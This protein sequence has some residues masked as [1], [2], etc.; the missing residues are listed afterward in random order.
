MQQFKVSFF[1][2]SKRNKEGK[3]LVQVRINL[4]GSRMFLCGTDI[5]LSASDWDS[6]LERVK[7]KTAEGRM[8][9]NRLESLES[10]V[11]HIFHKHEYDQNLSLDLI[12]SIYKG[13]V[14]T[15]NAKE[16]FMKFFERHV[17]DRKAE[18]GS[19]IS[20]SCYYKYSLTYR[21]F[22][23][24]L[25][26]EY[27]R[28]DISFCELDYTIITSFE[29]YMRK[30]LP[31]C[32]NNTL[33]RKMRVLKTIMIDARKH[34]MLNRDPFAGY[35]VHFTPTNRGFL[36]DEEVQRLIEKE[37][38]SKRLEQVRDF[39]LF[40]I[41][42]G[43][44][45][46]DIKNLTSKNIVEL[47][48]RI[49]IIKSREKTDVSSHIPM[50]PMAA[51]IIEKY[52]GQCKDEHLLPIPSNQKMNSY[53]KEIADFCGIDKRLTCHLGRHTFA[54]MTL[55]KGV[56]IESVSHMLGH[57]SIRTTQIYAR[58]TAK[59]IEQ[60]MDVFASKIG[61]FGNTPKPADLS[62]DP[63]KDALAIDSQYPVEPAR[64][65]TEKFRGR[66]RKVATK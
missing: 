6:K 57:T 60:D 43:L 15:V 9:N 8:I 4:N 59:K 62:S 41:F 35:K 47:N 39:F 63:H 38:H 23:D 33:M 49:W 29:R 25:K 30:T 2:H 21:H 58:I 12:K 40:S 66:P 54:T 31:E 36:E 51:S 27:Q 10:E 34:G 19:K 64:L 61:G 56:P 24:F 26:D 1:L 16:S 52:K 3:Q 7:L 18:V 50:L 14:A 42:T 45:Y 17:E 48:D 65:K 46:T 13:S 55:S 44:A 32:C 53:L 20:S 37:F 11:L 5:C 22:V 28:T